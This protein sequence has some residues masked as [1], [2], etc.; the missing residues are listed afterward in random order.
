VKPRARW[1]MLVAASALAAAWI[2][3]QLWRWSD[4]DLADVRARAE[5]MG[6]PWR[7]T[8]G[9]EADTTRTKAMVARVVALR[10][11]IQPFEDGREESSYHWVRIVN[12]GVP[13]AL[14]AHHASLD[15][16]AVRGFLSAFEELEGGMLS[17][18]IHAWADAAVVNARADVNPTVAS[19]ELAVWSA[20]HAS[21]L[22]WFAERL[23][24]APRGE[25]LPA[26]RQL[27]RLS[28]DGDG[29]VGM[30]LHLHVVLDAIGLAL[31]GLT[32]EERSVV[33]VDLRALAQRIPV[34]VVASARNA[35]SMA[36]LLLHARR[37]VDSWWETGKRIVGRSTRAVR[38]DRLLE[39]IA[40]FLQPLGIKDLI[41]RVRELGPSDA[42]TNM[43]MFEFEAGLEPAVAALAQIELLL[44]ELEARPWPPDPFEPT[45]APARVWEAGGLRF[46]VYSVGMDG[47]DD[48]ADPYSDDLRWRLRRAR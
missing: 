19:S 24:V 22:H 13:D 12:E 29:L 46:G 25:A 21:F 34:S 32:T 15:P 31:P 33:I 20:A 23:L 2:G 47:R 37:S 18:A 40:P 27:F 30:V 1:L 16:E 36:L 28:T 42:E 45:G 38:G 35:A 44:A 41:A 8:L 6:I 10:A 3:L 17:D 7:P 4:G 14:R 43:S 39:R 48:Q 26:I 11:R 5:C 9:Q